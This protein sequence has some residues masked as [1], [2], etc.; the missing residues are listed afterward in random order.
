[1]ENLRFK[2]IEIT[3]D[4]SNVDIVFPS[5]KASEYFGELTFNR[6]AMRE[7]LTEEAYT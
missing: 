1:M 7:Y 3:M 4:R 2:A 6:A 5:R